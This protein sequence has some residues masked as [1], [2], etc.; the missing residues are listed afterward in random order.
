MAPV[1]LRAGGPV[2]LRAPPRRRAVTARAQA[3]AP[4]AAPR[5]A[6]GARLAGLLASAAASGVGFVAGDL[7][8]Q[9]IG[10]EPLEAARVA[11]AGAFGFVVDGPV[12]HLLRSVSGKDRREAERGES[13]ALAVAVPAGEEPDAEG[14]A[15]A[16]SLGCVGLGL[17]FF[18]AVKLMEGRPD[19]IV[20]GFQVRRPPREGG[21][22]R[23]PFATACCL[24]RSLPGGRSSGLRIVC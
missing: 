24:A 20:N 10:G 15:K 7:L 11:Q 4:P 21:Q 18:A 22:G 17:A 23:S 8:A 2:A 19:E 3:L 9:R 12:R 1:R 16:A 13:E 5:S 14:V 6:A